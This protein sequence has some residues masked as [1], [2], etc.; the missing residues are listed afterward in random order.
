VDPLIVDEAHAVCGN[1]ERYAA[2]QTV[3]ERSRRVV[4]LTATPHSGDE[5]RFSRLVSLGELRDADERGAP[6]TPRAAGAPVRDDGDTLTILRRTRRDL[7]WPHARRPLAH[8]G[9]TG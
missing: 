7:G 6:R 8:V 3:A 4:L 1:S 5:T 9:Y 2:C